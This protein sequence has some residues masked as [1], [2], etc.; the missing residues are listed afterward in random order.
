M[1]GV[2]SQLDD[3]HHTMVETLWAEF[4]AH[5][6]LA[7]IHR[8]PIPHISYHVAENYMMS[9]LRNTLNIFSKQIPPFTM[10]TN[11]LGIFTGPMPVL[12]LPVRMESGLM[13][14]H[15]RL[16]DAV[17]PY[18]V[19]TLE[20]YTPHHWHPHITLA[21]HGLDY[22]MLAQIVRLLGRRSFQWEIEINNL[23]IIGGAPDTP[24][25]HHGILTEYKLGRYD[26]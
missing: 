22:D 11:G 14:I 2:V 23:S 21:Q 19:H 6:G 18:A 9:N 12:Y 8:V 26:E 24:G 1:Y 20:H 16:N 10:R 15:K 25:Q 7:T 17:N 5:F 13:N 4:A 3:K